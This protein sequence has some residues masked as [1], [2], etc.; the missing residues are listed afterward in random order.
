MLSR[1]LLTMFRLKK[2]EISIEYPSNVKSI[3]EVNYE[4]SLQFSMKFKLPFNKNQPHS[5]EEAPKEKESLVRIAPT[6]DHFIQSI[7]NATN[8]AADLII[9]AIPPNVTLIYIDNLVDDQTLNND[10]IANLL[11]N[12]QE[13]LEAIKVTLSIPEIVTSNLLQETVESMVNGSVVIHIDGCSQV[14]IGNIATR[15]S[16]SL[17]AP[18]NESQV[19]GTQVGFNE[20]LTTN[21]SLIRRYIVS[22]DLCNEKLKIGLRVPI[23]RSHY[24]I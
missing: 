13:T 23:P 7:R 12:P 18:E 1:D 5:F 6:T 22:P 8:N 15:E 21:I 14:L 17:S 9:K 2:H 19:I 4:G 24:Y 20:S 16:R 10:I 11:N 3:I